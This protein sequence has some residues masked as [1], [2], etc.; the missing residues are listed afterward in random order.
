MG[1]LPLAIHMPM[2]FTETESRDAGAFKHT[3]CILKAIEVD[4]DE[5]ERIQACDDAEI[6]LSE[7]ASRSL[8]GTR[9][10]GRNIADISLEAQVCHMEQR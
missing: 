9:N 7:A 8:R 6:A 3:R 10:E 2:R 4:A 5:Q 1:L